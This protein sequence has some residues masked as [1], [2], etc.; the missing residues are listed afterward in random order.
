MS[1]VQLG[2]KPSAKEDYYANTFFHIHRIFLYLF[3]LS[4]A[5]GVLY[6]FYSIWVAPYFPQKRKS[7][8]GDRSKKATP[9]KKSE[10]GA[11]GSDGSAVATGA[12]TY[13]EA[14]I[15]AHHIQRPEAKRAKSGTPKPKT[16]G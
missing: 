1:A 5:S 15:P 8:G 9:L 10:A 11:S 7:G 6:L 14:W 2:L 4:C 3:L 16:K 13:D 12:K